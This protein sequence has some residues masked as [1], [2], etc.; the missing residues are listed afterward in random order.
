MAALS[1]SNFCL[2]ALTGSGETSSEM[3][4]IS[5]ADKV[6]SSSFSSSSSSG[7]WVS[8]STSSVFGSACASVDAESVATILSASSTVTLLSTCNSD[9]SSLASFSSSATSSIFAASFSASC[10]SSA[11]SAFFASSASRCFFSS[12]IN[13][14]WCSNTSSFNFN[15]SGSLF[16]SSGV[17][18]S[19][20]TSFTTSLSNP[21]IAS[22]KPA[23]LLLPSVSTDALLAISSLKKK[24]LLMINNEIG[25]FLFT[26]KSIHC[27]KDRLYAS[28]LI[29]VDLIPLSWHASLN[30]IFVNESIP[31]HKI[32]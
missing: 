18:L 25:T 16:L 17:T 13:S 6:L 12:W 8:L 15:S 11:C 22:A 31:S 9:P 26:L 23:T 3:A 21:E 30:S 19:K 1:N 4:S 2:S 20:I 28:L 29:P 24:V 10:F 27:C 14:F 7:V 5:S 32:R